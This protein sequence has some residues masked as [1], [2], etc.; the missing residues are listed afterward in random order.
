LAASKRFID[1]NVD[2]RDIARVNKRLDKWQGKPL[3][4][5]LQKAVTGGASLMVNPIRAFAPQSASGTTGRYA[6][7]S[8][9]LKRK[10]RTRTLRK[11]PGEAAAAYAGPSTFYALFVRYGTS[12]GIQANSFVE[13]AESFNEARVQ[14]F[15][16]DTVRRLA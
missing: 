3:A 9:N 8:G 14:R 10:V 12:R 2:Q 4:T 13:R 16:D 15:I 6:H 1:F 7:K 11:R 5:R